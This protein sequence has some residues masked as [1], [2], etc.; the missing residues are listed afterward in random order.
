VDT[1][2][3][4]PFDLMSRCGKVFESA[5]F[6][7]NCSPDVAVVVAKAVSELT[8]FAAVA[9]A[10]KLTNSN[11]SCL[12]EE[13]KPNSRN[14][15]APKIASWL[16]L[17]AEQELGESWVRESPVS[18]EMPGQ[19]WCGS[20]IRFQ[21]RILGCLAVPLT[22]TSV[23]Y[24]TEE[25]RGF[26]SVLTA[27]LAGLLTIKDVLITL[28]PGQLGYLSRLKTVSEMAGLAAHELNN[29]LNGILLNTALLEQEMSPD[30]RAELAVIRKLGLEAGAIVKKLQHLNQQPPFAL[31][32]VDLNQLVRDALTS[33]ATGEQ[34]LRLSVHL[35]AG[36]PLVQG[37]R[38][39]LLSLLSTL[40]NA[41]KG[42]VAS[43]AAAITVQTGRVHNKAFF[44]ITDSGPK[45]ET[46]RLPHIFEPFYPARGTDDGTTYPICKM[47]ARAVQGTIQVESQPEGGLS[48]QVELEL[49]GRAM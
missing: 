22:A 42:A 4:K 15:L 18:C 25:A 21:H 46:E 39:V 9:C 14:R 11:S 26:L 8:G 47:L 48:V 41:A 24:P 49:A 19:S 34:S 31:E 40:F 30:K 37:S 23:S 28:A 1:L 5:L 13:A 17:A 32:P 16:L 36:L 6:A 7:D 44:R 12:W 38:Q 45:I 10:L 20:A 33:S 43:D 3:Q 35:D 2:T 27:Q 29:Y